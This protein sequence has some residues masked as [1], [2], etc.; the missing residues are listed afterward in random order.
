MGLSCALPLSAPLQQPPPKFLLLSYVQLL[1]RS[2]CRAAPVCFVQCSNAP[3]GT[4]HSQALAHPSREG[5]KGAKRRRAA[6]HLRSDDE[7]GCSYWDREGEE[8]V[9]SMMEQSLEGRREKQQQG[10]TC[11]GVWKGEKEMAR[12]KRR[13]HHAQISRQIQSM[14]WEDSQPVVH[15]L[16]SMTNLHFYFLLSIPHSDTWRKKES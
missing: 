11:K 16:P 15:F 1:L 7:K 10:I 3:P 9:Q 14:G 4:K 5:V 13:G 2:G 6:R 8:T 12:L